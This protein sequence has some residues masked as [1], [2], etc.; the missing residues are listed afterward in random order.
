[1]RPGSAYAR[2][3]ED[4]FFEAFGISPSLNLLRRRLADS[5]TPRLPRTGEGRGA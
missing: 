2:P 5:K 4:R 3:R 1:M